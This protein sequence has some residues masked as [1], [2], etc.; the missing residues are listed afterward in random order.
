MVKKHAGVHP[1]LYA[2]LQNKQSV[3]CMRM[4]EMIREM[5][6][7]ARPDAI[8]CDFEYAAFATMKDCF[9]DVEIR[10]CLF[11]LLQNL[12]KQIKSMGLMGS[13]NSNPDLALH[14]K[15]VT[16]LSF[17]PNDDIDRHVDALAMDLSG[18]L[19][20]VLN[21][22]EDNYIGRPYRRGTGKRQPL[23]LTEMWNMYQRTL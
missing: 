20:P 5:V 21:W 10:G 19:V 8:N 17:V 9:S 16:A 12:L 6:P 22:F 4:I 23:F 2:L 1:V 14:A 3:T 15:M 7:N 13:Y 18:E 11:H